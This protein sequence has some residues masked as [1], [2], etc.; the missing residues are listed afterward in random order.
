MT[1][2]LLT[3]KPWQVA[4]LCVVGMAVV[5]GLYLA[6]DLNYIVGYF[7]DGIQD[8]TGFYV[9]AEL[10]GTPGLYSVEENVARQRTL[11]RD[12]RAS[13]IFVRPAYFALMLRPLTRLPYVAAMRLWKALILAAVGAFLII[14]PIGPFRL[15]A[16]AV[17]SSVPL[18]G[19]FLLGQD[20]PFVML[21]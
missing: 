10:V 1:P 18:A 4:G 3:L 2:N 14:F 17:C 21:W 19:A 9:G 20:S 6:G 8:F 12:E 16:L 7:S 5:I 11:V 13:I 15:R